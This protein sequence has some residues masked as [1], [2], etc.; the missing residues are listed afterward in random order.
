MKT[1][2]GALFGLVSPGA[3]KNLIPIK[4]A[5]LLNGSLIVGPQVSSLRVSSLQWLTSAA[6]SAL[7]RWGLPGGSD[8]DDAGPVTLL[9]INDLTS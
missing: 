3:G 2:V 9:N 4:D 8:D 6:T 7:Y 5:E 1:A